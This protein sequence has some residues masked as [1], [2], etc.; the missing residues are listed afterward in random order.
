M[1]VPGEFET[2]LSLPFRIEYR[3]TS[4]GELEITAIIPLAACLPAELRLDFDS[5]PA[6]ERRCLRIA[7]ERDARRQRAG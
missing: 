3:E 6:H 5:L 1:S 2:E 7:A 4:D